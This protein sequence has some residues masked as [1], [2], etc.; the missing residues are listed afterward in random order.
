[1]QATST[2]DAP[3]R[4]VPEA[5]QQRRNHRQE[6]QE[7][8]QLGG[9]PDPANPAPELLDSSWQGQRVVAHGD[10][11]DL[12]L[13]EKAV[14]ATSATAQTTM[15]L[16]TGRQRGD[17]RWPVGYSKPSRKMAAVVGGSR[18]VPA[19]ATITAPG[20]TGSVTA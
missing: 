2:A 6:Q 4:G 17:G 20:F 13:Q 12:D 9:E 3:R 11:A 14:K 19:Q 10:L 8:E 18:R 16:A 15:A 7:G 5:D 1:M